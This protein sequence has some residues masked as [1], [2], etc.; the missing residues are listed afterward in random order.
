MFTGIIEQLG[1]VE[2]LTL[3]K[4]NMLITV[5]CEFIDDLNINQSIS[6]NG[7]CLSV[8]E[9][10]DTNYTVCAV[11]ETLQKTN[12]KFLKKGENINLERC[13]AVGDRIDGHI[14]QGHVD[15]TV[16][17]IE[18]KDLNGSWKLTFEQ[19]S[20][21]NKYVITKGSVALNGIS[22]TISDI[23]PSNNRFSV[24]IIPYTY[25]NTNIKDV[26]EESLVNVE[27]DIFAKQIA[28]LQ[29]LS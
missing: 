6:H 19:K 5:K 20:E 15:G 22:L 10:T 12:L 4:S 3:N 29:Q 16:K 28:H 18:K 2:N 21:Y 7:I 25:D 9:M 24:D 11:K 23:N 1:K 14:V 27:Y 13:L 17:C 26:L 8:H